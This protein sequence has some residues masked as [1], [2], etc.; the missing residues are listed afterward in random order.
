MLEI[1]KEYCL[2]DDGKVKNTNIFFKGLGRY[3][4]INYP[5]KLDELRQIIRT[6]GGTIKMALWLVEEDIL[7][8]DNNWC[9]CN[10]GRWK[11]VK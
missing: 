5:D 2:Y 1:I 4:E 11:V 6:K 7:K 9:V 10:G 3:L 8:K